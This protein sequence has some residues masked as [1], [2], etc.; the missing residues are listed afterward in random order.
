MT[1]TQT[2]PKDAYRP[3]SAGQLAA[4]CGVAVS[5]V[6]FCEAKGLIRS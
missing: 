6:H 3:L 2:T 5:T 1:R 4:R